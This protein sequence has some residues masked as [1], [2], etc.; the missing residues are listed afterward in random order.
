M[1]IFFMISQKVGP[2]FHFT[3]SWGGGKLGEGARQNFRGGIPPHPPGAATD[4]G[5]TDDFRETHG[6]ERMQFLFKSVCGDLFLRQSFWYL[7]KGLY[8][9]TDEYIHEDATS[10]T[11]DIRFLNVTFEDYIT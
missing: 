7:N 6:I 2:F 8:F 5:Y 1:P 11:R 4:H 3:E 10:W 9:R